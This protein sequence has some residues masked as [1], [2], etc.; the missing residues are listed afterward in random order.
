MPRDGTKIDGLT[1]ISLLLP[2][3]TKRGFGN[4]DPKA[5]SRFIWRVGLGQWRR[6]QDKT[7]IKVIKK[8]AKMSKT[9]DAI[10]AAIPNTIAPQALARV[11]EA[12]GRG[13][14]SNISLHLATTPQLYQ[15]DAQPIEQVNELLQ[16]QYLCGTNV[17]FVKW[18]ARKGAVVP[19]THHVNEQIT[20]ITEGT[21]DVYSQGQKYTMRAGDIMIIPPNIPHEFIFTEDTIDIDIFA[22]TRQDWLDGTATYLSGK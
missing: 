12:P 18:I 14:I 2:S 15:L 4:N 8:E 19:L 13:V 10:N 20:W 22:P 6:F 9:E 1:Q 21:C 7:Q 17:T 16:R 3:F 11:E 5:V